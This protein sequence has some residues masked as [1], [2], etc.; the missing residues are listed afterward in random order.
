[1]NKHSRNSRGA[2]KWNMKQKLQTFVSELLANETVNFKCP[3][4]SEWSSNR[5][6]GIG[7]F[8]WNYYLFT[9]SVNK[10]SC[11]N[12]EIYTHKGY[13][14]LFQK[15][16]NWKRNDVNWYDIVQT[17]SKKFDCAK[18]DVVQT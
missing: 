8:I 18:F 6:Y 1:M 5:Y 2:G 11:T 4:R 10:Q 9:H 15:S 17:K 3:K 14:R 7:Y 16:K 12:W 13:K